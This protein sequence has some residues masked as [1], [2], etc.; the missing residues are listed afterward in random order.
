MILESAALTRH[1]VT[2][3]QTGF[4]RRPAHKPRSCSNGGFAAAVSPAAVAR[5]CS[6][7]GGRACLSGAYAALRSRGNSSSPFAV[8]LI[9]AVQRMARNRE[10]MR[11]LH[12]SCTP[13]NHE[14][15]LVEEER[16]TATWQP[17]AV[18]TPPVVLRRL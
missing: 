5:K 12:G 8:V 14:C 16:L 7:L 13:V 4:A 1:N 10:S 11:R 3:L 15:V 9:G 17:P 2:V 18:S 6:V